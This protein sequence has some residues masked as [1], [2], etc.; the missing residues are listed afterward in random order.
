MSDSIK[1]YA[2]I[3]VITTAG[4]ITYSIF[5]MS[6]KEKFSYKFFTLDPSFLI[7]SEDEQ[8]L[9]VCDGEVLTDKYDKEDITVTVTRDGSH[10]NYSNLLIQKS[11]IIS[12]EERERC[13]VY[14]DPDDGSIS[15]TP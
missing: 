10:M 1:K 13:L 6:D 3:Y 15:G 14:V 8:L 7:D 11:A 4:Q 12:I 2:D 9:I 5:I